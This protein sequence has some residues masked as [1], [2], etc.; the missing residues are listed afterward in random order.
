MAGF[1]TYKV[2]QATGD[3]VLVVMDPLTGFFFTTD[4]N[5][6]ES[7]LDA[8]VANYAAAEFSRIESFWFQRA[9][10]PSAIPAGI[11]Q[12]VIA[13]RASAPLTIDDLGVNAYGQWQWIYW[14][15]TNIVSLGAIAA[16]TD[17]I[18]VVTDALT[19]AAAANMETVWNGVEGFAGAYAGPRGPGVYLNDAAGNTN[20]VNGV[21]GTWSNPVSTIAAAKTIA[22]SLSV[23]RVYLVNDSSITLSATMEDYEFVGIGEMTKNVINFGSQDVD[24]SVFYNLVLTGAQGGTTRCQAEDCVLSTITGMEITALRCVVADGGTLT[25]RNDCAF[26]AC[27]SAV[28]GSGT[29]TLD[30]NSVANVNVYFRHYS[31]GLQVDNAVATTVISFE[32]DGQIV[33]DA[34]CTSLTLVVRGNCS[35]TDNGTTTSLSQDAA[36]TRDAIATAFLDLANGVETGV[37]PREYFQ[38]AGA[39]VAGKI[40][41]AGTGTEIFVGMDGATNR[42]T[43]TVDGTGNRSV[44][45][46][47]P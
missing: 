38:R 25:L 24:H 17:A 11:Y 44:M 19:A 7:P 10:F 22:D 45:A 34:T 36:I 29:P 37:T 46:Y 16:A 9:E 28:A 26:D 15:G 14:D 18:K 47:D 6:F 32:A 40:S 30:I 5:T 27:F 4:G 12:Y 41:G 8:N 43:V 1:I 21:D 23:D 35:I 13:L 33:V 3:F 2:F 31:G 20:T 42:V 39:V